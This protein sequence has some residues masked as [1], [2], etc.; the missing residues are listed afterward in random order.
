[1]KKYAPLIVAIVAGIST[2]LTN[3]LSIDVALGK[4]VETRFFAFLYLG[5]DLFKLELAVLVVFVLIHRPLA[6]LIAQAARTTIKSVRT[7]RPEKTFWHLVG[8]FAI[9]AAA[10]LFIVYQGYYLALGKYSMW[11]EHDR[12]LVRLAADYFLRG[13]HERAKLLLSACNT[14]YDTCRDTASST[15]PTSS[16]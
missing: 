11:V 10:T 16:G 9:V 3:L 14:V 12:S 2:L 6:R 1:M 8:G 13:E 7:E 4:L 5:W 15:A